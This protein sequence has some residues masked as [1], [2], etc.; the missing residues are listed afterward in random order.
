MALTPLWVLQAKSSAQTQKTLCQT[1]STKN[2]QLTSHPKI[3]HHYQEYFQDKKEGLCRGIQKLISL[4][5]FVLTSR[6]WNL[7]LPCYLGL[8]KVGWWGSICGCGRNWCL[9][10]GGVSCNKK[11]VWC[12]RHWRINLVIKGLWNRKEVVFFGWVHGWLG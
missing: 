11:M 12:K 7:F 10:D 1:K 2:F 3:H 6:L 4:L 5:K 8:G 9:K